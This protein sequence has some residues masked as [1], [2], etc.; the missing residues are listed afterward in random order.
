MKRGRKRSKNQKRRDARYLRWRNLRD[1]IS[2][3]A[4]MC[5]SPVAAWLLLM[6][7]PDAPSL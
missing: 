3:A 4:D 5:Q 1:E 6:S 2:R 7:L